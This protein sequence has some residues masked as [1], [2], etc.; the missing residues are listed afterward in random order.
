MSRPAANPLANLVRTAGAAKHR[1]VHRVS[2][3]GRRANQQAAFDNWQEFR[4]ALRRTDD[5]ETVLRT[6]AGVRIAVR[7]NRYDAMIVGEQFITC[8]YVRHFTAPEGRRPVVVD[9]GGYIGDFTVWCAATLDAQVIVYEPAA[10]NWAMLTR[11]LGLN[12]DLAERITAVQRGV[13]STDEVQANV[14][15]HGNE[16]HVS[17]Q[18]YGDDPAAHRRTFPCDTLPE[19]VERAGGHVDLLKVDCEGA[20]YDIFD[21]A[22]PEVYAACDLIVFERHRIPGWKERL[23]TIE[24][25]MTHAGLRIIRHGDL[26]H[27]RRG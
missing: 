5:G 13:A 10:E 21:G 2:P 15:V 14:V 4:S 26:I 6:H 9:I 8:D 11:N 27:A 18:W 17:S 1:L 19:I 3:A 24:S 22:T 7:H 16:V 20:E 12:P 25:A 23:E